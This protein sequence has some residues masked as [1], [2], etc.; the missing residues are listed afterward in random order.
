[1]W[2]A[3][4]YGFTRSNKTIH[5]ICSYNSR[6]LLLVAI[7]RG[8]NHWIRV[9]VHF[10]AFSLIVAMCSRIFARCWICCSRWWWCIVDYR[11]CCLLQFNFILFES[12]TS[13]IVLIAW[14]ILNVNTYILF[15]SPWSRLKIAHMC[16]GS[17][18]LTSNN[19]PCITTNTIHTGETDFNIN[20]R[21]A[22]STSQQIYTHAHK[23]TQE[24]EELLTDRIKSL[25]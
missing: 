1:M 25:A 12:L 19:K 2:F 9:C 16:S 4:H 23:R 7:M 18:L 15:Y 5:S 11:L 21:V 6:R 14:N 24:N 22:K 20:T 13:N 8:G 3:L 10:F 17:A